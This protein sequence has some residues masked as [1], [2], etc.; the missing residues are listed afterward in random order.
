MKVS[1]VTPS[2]NQAEYLTTCLRS[3]GMQSYR[4]VGHIVVDGGSEDGSLDILETFQAKDSRLRFSSGPD[5]G[6]GDAVNK[7]LSLAF[8]DIIA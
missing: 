8:G 6:Q 7:G 4:N 1:I 2:Y 3:V 5:H